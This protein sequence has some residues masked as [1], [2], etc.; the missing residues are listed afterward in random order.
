MHAHILYCHSSSVMQ[1]RFS[2]VLYCQPRLCSC[3]LLPTLTQLTFCIVAHIMHWQPRQFS[4]SVFPTLSL[5]TISIANPDSFHVLNCLPYVCSCSVYLALTLLIF[6]IAIANP[7]SAHIIYCK[8]CSVLPKQTRLVFSIVNTYSALIWQG[9]ILISCL[10]VLKLWIQVLRG[11][12]MVTLQTLAPQNL[13]SCRWEGKRPVS[14]ICR[15][16]ERRPQSAW[17]EIF[18]QIKFF[19]F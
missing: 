5:F 13:C 12:L 2:H 1:L 18:T 16:R 19:E 8:S 7:N 14:S 17:S 3:S 15:H 10:R 4:C 9:S 11:C 6:C